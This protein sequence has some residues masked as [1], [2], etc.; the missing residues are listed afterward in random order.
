MSQL[1]LQRY[2]YRAATKSEFDQAWTVAA[3]AF[4]RTGNFGAV[5]SGVRHLKGYGTGWGGYCL[6]EVDDPAAFARYQLFHNQNYGHMAD[7]T[8]EPLFDSDAALA[9]RINELKR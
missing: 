6:I 1:F 3:E 2:Q 7:V 4:A 8:F 9:P 5:E